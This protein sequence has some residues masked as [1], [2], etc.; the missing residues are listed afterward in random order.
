MAAQVAPCGVHRTD[1]PCFQHKADVLERD[2]FTSVQRDHG[3]TSLK[4][5]R[6][7]RVR[8]HPHDVFVHRQARIDIAYRKDRAIRIAP[9]AKIEIPA[10]G[11]RLDQH[12]RLGMGLAPSSPIRG[13]HAGLFQLQAPPGQSPVTARPRKVSN[14]E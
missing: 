11:Q 2:L 13:D 4:R 5:D 7:A 3:G 9:V 10:E 6:P 14:T 1:A 12:S 8:H